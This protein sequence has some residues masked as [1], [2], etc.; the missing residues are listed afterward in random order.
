[1]KV[2]LVDDEPLTTESL[3]RYID[4]KGLGILEVRTASNGLEALELLPRF[5]PDVIVS[6][7][8]MPRMN[9]IEFA[10]AARE[11]YPDIKIIFLS[12]YSDKEYL[13]SAIHLKALSYVEK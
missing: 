11:R 4:W 8:R 5:N 13:K 10:T 1:M 3:E 6:D 7:V 2:L 9:G 12:G